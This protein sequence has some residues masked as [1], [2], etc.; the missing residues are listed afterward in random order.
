MP[1]WILWETWLV[2][3]TVEGK[4]ADLSETVATL[5]KKK[6]ELLLYKKNKK[7]K[8]VSKDV[9]HALVDAEVISN[10]SEWPL[11]IASVAVSNGSAA[12][13]LRYRTACDS[14]N[15]IVNP[16]SFV[17]LL[18]ECYGEQLSC[19][20]IHR[21]RILLRPSE[22]P[23]VDLRELRSLCRMDGHLAAAKRNTALLAQ[24]LQQ[25]VIL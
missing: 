21:S 7:G 22:Q 14:G 23:K 19:M 10:A 9:R 4:E 1:W 20:H 25:T 6:C 18:S 3:R 16:A 24:N 12:S 8:K 15:P 17:K 13:V 2:V 5:L 11:T